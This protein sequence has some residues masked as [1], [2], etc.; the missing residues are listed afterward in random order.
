MS[1]CLKPSIALSL[2]LEYNAKCSQRPIRCVGFSST[3]TS[4]SIPHSLLSSHVEPF[5][6]PGKCQ[7]FSCVRI[8]HLLPLLPGC[9][10]SSLVGQIPLILQDSVQDAK[11]ILHL[12][13]YALYSMDVTPQ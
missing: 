9:L 13:I 2:H 4:Y 7:D 5:S 12:E 10:P 1:I 6:D 11:N 3:H 8:L